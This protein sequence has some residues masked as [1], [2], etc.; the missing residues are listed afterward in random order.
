[1]IIFKHY[2]TNAL[3][4]YKD[5]NNPE[6]HHKTMDFLCTLICIV[7]SKAEGNSY[8]WWVWKHFCNNLGC[9][10]EEAWQRK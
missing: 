9:H 3:K 5:Q 10:W 7:Q 2:F 8:R 6:S 1:M 4:S